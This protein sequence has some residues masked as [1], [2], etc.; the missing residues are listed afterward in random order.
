MIQCQILQTNI[1]R[2]IWQTVRRITNEILGVKRSKI[3]YWK[4][5]KVQVRRF[6]LSLGIYQYISPFF[7]DVVG[8][9][10]H[11]SSPIRRVF[12]FQESNIRK[13]LCIVARLLRKSNR[14]YSNQN[15]NSCFWLIFYLTLVFFLLG[16]LFF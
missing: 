5:D 10:L 16:K 3:R 1:T 9:V 7:D 13:Y 4:Q 8:W 15:T 6:F 14:E 12:N 11:L 2:T